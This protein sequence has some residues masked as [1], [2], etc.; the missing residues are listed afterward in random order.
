[1]EQVYW[2][3]PSPDDSD[4]R[5][6]HYRY[7]NFVYSGQVVTEPVRGLEYLPGVLAGIQA[8]QGQVP[9]LCE[10]GAL[11]KE[12]PQLMSLLVL[13]RAMDAIHAEL[14]ALMD[15]IAAKAAIAG[16]EWIDGDDP[17][18]FEFEALP[19]YE[20]GVSLLQHMNMGPRLTFSHRETRRGYHRRPLP[21]LP[22]TLTLSYNTMTAGSRSDIR[23]ELPRRTNALRHLVRATCVLLRDAL[24]CLQRR[25]D[26]RRH[27]ISTGSSLE[28][29]AVISL[30]RDENYSPPPR[31]PS[32]RFTE[33]DADLR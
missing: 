15:T 12:S 9:Y 28:C 13:Q 11:E 16:N 17:T 19:G 27:C 3:S 20:C 2:L 6:L 8:V 18:Y 22:P 7:G 31:H 30:R 23:K 24:P 1:M 33:N 25:T 14:E 32:S 29:G 26:S 5:T 10:V 4:T 21:P